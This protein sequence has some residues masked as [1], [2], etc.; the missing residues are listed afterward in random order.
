MWNQFVDLFLLL[1]QSSSHPPKAKTAMKWRKMKKLKHRSKDGGKVGSKRAP[2]GKHT[3]AKK[4]ST[5]QIEAQRREQGRKRIPRVS[6]TPLSAPRTE[7]PK[8]CPKPPSV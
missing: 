4:H 5:E 7:T 6:I 3:C 8:G 2:R 1:N